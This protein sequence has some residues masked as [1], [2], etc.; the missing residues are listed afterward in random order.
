[1]LEEGLPAA[2]PREYTDSQETT[3]VVVASE[4]YAQ[5]LNRCQAFYISLVECPENCGLFWDT[6]PNT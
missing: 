6:N 1:M 2:R 5:I 4:T 3:L